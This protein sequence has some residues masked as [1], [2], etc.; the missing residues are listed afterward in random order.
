MVA[1]P[2][3]ISYGR[4]KGIAKACQEISVIFKEPPHS[5]TLINVEGK[6]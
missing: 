4:L 3:E 6:A 2:W 1:V 5:R